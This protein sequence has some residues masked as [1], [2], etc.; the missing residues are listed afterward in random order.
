[1]GSDRLSNA[2]DGRLPPQPSGPWPFCPGALLRLPYRS[3]GGICSV[4]APRPGAKWP[5]A[6]APDTSKRA[7]SPGDHHPMKAP[8]RNA[9][10]SVM[11]AVSDTP[12]AVAW[13]EKALGARLLWTLGSVAGMEIG[14]AAFFVHEPVEGHFRAPQDVG[15]TTV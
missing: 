11:L 12:K 3:T 2:A 6:A 15:T 4:G 8:N 1:M 10:I 13:Y 7:L 9:I 14:G 5:A